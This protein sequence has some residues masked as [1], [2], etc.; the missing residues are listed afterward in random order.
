MK[1]T[2]T[3]YLNIQVSVSGL[4]HLEFKWPL[5]RNFDLIYF[6][7]IRRNED[8]YLM[9]SIFASKICQVWIYSKYSKRYAILPSFIFINHFFSIFINLILSRN[10]LHHA[11]NKCSRYPKTLSFNGFT[12]DLLMRN[13]QP[14]FTKNMQYLYW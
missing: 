5:F 4:L 10:E 9:S 7:R 13:I 1:Y 6:D 2:L 3:Y 11:S 12:S 8:S 14:A